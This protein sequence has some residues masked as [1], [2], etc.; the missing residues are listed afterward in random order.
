LRWPADLE[1]EAPSAPAEAIAP[2]ARARDDCA[3]VAATLRAGAVAI[4][5]FQ[6]G[7]TLLDRAEFPL[8]FAQTAPL[9]IASI[10]VG[11]LAFMATLS[12][13]AMRNWRGF[14]LATSAAIIA[15]TSWIVSRCR[16]STATKRRPR[17]AAGSGRTIAAARP[18]WR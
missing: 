17:F 7:Y 18:L 11:L 9:H 1:V 3:R 4:I 10:T 5:A 15:I 6:V 16:S 12:P 13:R 14:A 2:V 8:T